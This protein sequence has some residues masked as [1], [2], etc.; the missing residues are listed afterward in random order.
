MKNLLIQQPELLHPDSSAVISSTLCLF[1]KPKRIRNAP[2]IKCNV[3]LVNVG[4]SHAFIFGAFNT[5][6]ALPVIHARES[7]LHVETYYAS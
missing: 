2:A 7:P 4:D 5:K 3:F 1:P 6:C